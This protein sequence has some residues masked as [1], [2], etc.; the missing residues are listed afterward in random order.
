MLEKLLISLN[1]R[2]LPLKVNYKLKDIF[3]DFF[4]LK[5]VKQGKLTFTGFC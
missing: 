4:V 3:C 2:T 1:G 5:S